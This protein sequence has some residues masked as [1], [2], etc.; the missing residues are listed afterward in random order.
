MHHLASEL[1]EL[2]VLG[3]HFCNNSANDK[4]K[5]EEKEYVHKVTRGINKIMMFI[6][7]IFVKFVYES[8]SLM[9]SFYFAVISIW[10]IQNKIDTS[11]IS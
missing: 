4:Y 10:Q 5:E 2:C 9:S 3:H 1:H 6:L 11:I 7:H 8:F